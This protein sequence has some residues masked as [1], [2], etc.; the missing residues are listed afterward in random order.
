MHMKE[1]GRRRDRG[2]GRE[3]GREWEE[4]GREWSPLLSTQ[5]TEEPQPGD[6]YWASILQLSAGNH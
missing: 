4:G 2:S 6:A 5:H 1:G 3:G